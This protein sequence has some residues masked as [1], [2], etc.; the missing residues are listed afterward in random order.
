MI[1]FAF[2]VI[3]IVYLEWGFRDKAYLYVMIV[4]AVYFTL[5]EIISLYIN[6]LGY[7]FDFWNYF[8]LCR[9]VLIYV[10]AIVRIS[11][12]D[13]I[14]NAEA[15]GESPET[16]SKRGLIIYA[17]MNFFV[18]VRLIS[19]LRLFSNT[20]ALIRLIVETM[21]DMI[22]FGIVL[23]VSAAMFVVV[24]HILNFEEN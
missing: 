21:K 1:L 2:A 23:I 15:S 22:P 10:Y 11:K 17:V 7:F 8:D 12:I 6:T 4:F 16:R 24:M 18:W 19:Y 3:C 9:I 5:N 13:E 20:R 14:S